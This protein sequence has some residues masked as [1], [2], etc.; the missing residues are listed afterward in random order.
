MKIYILMQSDINTNIKFHLF[1]KVFKRIYS[2][3]YLILET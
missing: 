3:H 1:T 2:I